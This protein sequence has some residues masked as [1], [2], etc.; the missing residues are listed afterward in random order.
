MSAAGDAPYDVVI[1]GPGI[2]GLATA[3]K[4]RATAS[5]AIGG[6]LATR[7]MTQFGLDA[8]KRTA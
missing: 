2:A 8:I 3:L 6:E 7:A 4:L 1:A 5:L